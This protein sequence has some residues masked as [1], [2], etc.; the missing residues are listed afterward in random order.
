MSSPSW[1]EDSSR[2]QENLTHALTQAR[3]HAASRSA[4][5]PSTVAY[6]HTRIMDGLDVPDQAWVGRYR[7]EAGVEVDV[8]VGPCLGAPHGRVSAELAFFFGR[9]HRAVEELDAVIPEGVTPEGSD[10]LHAV[11][12]LSAWVHARWV[13]IHPFVNGN[14]RVA[15]LLANWVAMRYGL[16]PFVQLRPR[17]EGAAYADAARAALCDGDWESSGPVFRSMFF[18]AQD[19]AGG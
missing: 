14:G 4:L 6:W 3:Q 19:E 11:L 12:T 1:D 2:L 15:R 13:E 8:R 10:L 16:I 5:E 17:P 7:G 18:R 9:L